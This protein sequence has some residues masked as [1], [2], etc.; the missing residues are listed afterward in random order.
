MNIDEKIILQFEKLGIRI[1]E[2]RENRNL[3]IKELS[4]K[5]GIRTEYLRKIESGKAFGILFEKHIVKIAKG[6]NVKISELFDY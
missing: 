1:K 5:T 2:F 3:T 4:Q 6:M